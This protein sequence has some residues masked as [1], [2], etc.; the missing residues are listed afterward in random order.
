MDIIITGIPDSIVER[1]LQEFVKRFVEMKIN[2][3]TKEERDAQTARQAL[4]KEAVSVVRVKAVKEK[5]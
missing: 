5:L 4:A 2:Q 1:E 3:P